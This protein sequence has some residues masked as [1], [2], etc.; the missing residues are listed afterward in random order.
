MIKLH[1]VSRKYI[2]LFMHNNRYLPLT[3]LLTYFVLPEKN[4]EFLKIF[5]KHFTKYFIK[6]CCY[7]YGRPYK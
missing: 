3:G 5:Q 2:M 6:G 4:C 7:S 1:E